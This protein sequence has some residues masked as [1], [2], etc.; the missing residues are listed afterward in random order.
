MQKRRA[1]IKLSE[2]ARERALYVIKLGT[3]EYRGY[4]RKRNGVEGIPSVLR[5]SYSVDS[6]PV[7]GYLCSKLWFGIKIGAINA[8]RVIAATLLLLDSSVIRAFSALTSNKQ[9]FFGHVRLY[10]A[11][12][13]YAGA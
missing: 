8:K 13:S 7:R 6:M 4:A 9:S 3:D 12:F 10:L 1:L 11:R 2:Q 5:R